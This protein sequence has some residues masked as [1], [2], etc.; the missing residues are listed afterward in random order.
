MVAIGCDHGGFALL[1]A[2]KESLDERKIEYRCFGA[3]S[4]ESVDYPPVAA[5]V[6]RLVASGECEAGILVCGTGIGMSITANKIKGIRAAV[7]SDAYSCEYTRRHNNANILCM[8]ARV[9]DG[10]KCRELAGIFMDTPFDGGRHQ[11]RVDMIG[12]IESGEL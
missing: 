10:D 2:V 3:S 11:R 8:G 6:A 4:E 5:E 1:N 9:I 12:K 7:C